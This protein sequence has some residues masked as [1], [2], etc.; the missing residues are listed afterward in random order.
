MSESRRDR[1]TP[2]IEEQMR[3]KDKREELIKRMYEQA[4]ELAARLRNNE[5]LTAEDLAVRVNLSV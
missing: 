3:D 4:Q 2:A 1:P 5:R